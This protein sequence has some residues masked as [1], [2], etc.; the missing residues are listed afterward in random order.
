MNCRESA[1]CRIDNA[2]IPWLKDYKVATWWMGDNTLLDWTEEDFDRQ[3]RLF[4]QQGFTAVDPSNFHFRWSWMEGDKE[5]LMRQARRTA[6]AAHRHGLKYIEHHSAVVMHRA[7]L[8]PATEAELMEH[9]NAVGKDMR[10]DIKRHPAFVKG[11]LHG[12]VYQGRNLDEMSQLDLGT[13]LR[14]GTW[15]TG[16]HAMALCSNNPDFRKMSF[17]YL[18]ELYE[19]GVDGI[20]P[21]DV[22]FYPRLNSCG[23]PHCREKFKRFSGY[24][25]PNTPEDVAKFLRD[26]EDPRMKAWIRF[27]RDSV[28]DYQREVTRQMR[29]S[30][31]NVMRPFYHS[32]ATTTGN[33]L[34]GG[35]ID[36]AAPY[37]SLLFTEVI[38][39]T[40]LPYSWER[41]G[42][43]LLQRLALGRRHDMPVQAQFYPL[44]DDAA[45][46]CIAFAALLEQGYLGTTYHAQSGQ[47]P[48]Q[49]ERVFDLIKSRSELFAAPQSMSRVKLLFSHVTRDNYGG[50]EDAFYIWEWAGWCEAMLRGRIPF[51]VILHEDIEEDA[52]LE[53][54]DLLILPNMACMSPRQAEQI[55]RFVAAGGKLIAT[56]ESSLYDAQG[57]ALRDFQLGD[58][59]GL[60]YVRT[61]GR[62]HPDFVV[63]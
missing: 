6:E 11:F 5:N 3:A 32:S 29:A 13:G 15:Y 24:D 37:C 55:R 8:R 17:G 10:F 18:E 41:V 43:E 2:A 53:E 12:V 27:R 19:L 56:H 45:S 4:K 14:A 40:I 7:S 62:I 34:T 33:N 61:E 59:F 26:Y 57:N 30:G 31:R 39:P 9:L 25:L 36:Q 48:T 47:P 49:F 35:S 44:D 60:Q 42:S 54:T 50:M 20:L 46:F 23:C 16:G 22:M 21:D 58:V 63:R 28:A 38:W 52:W 51:D 1:D